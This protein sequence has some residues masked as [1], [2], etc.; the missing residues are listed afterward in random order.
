MTYYTVV[1][2]QTF[3][4]GVKQSA[5]GGAGKLPRCCHLS[6]ILKDEY[7]Y[8]RKRQDKGKG[9]GFKTSEKQK[10]NKTTPKHKSYCV[11]E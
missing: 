6:F 10:Q 11:R 1:Q 7:M 4:H 8:A 2:M 3:S 9:G 5:Q